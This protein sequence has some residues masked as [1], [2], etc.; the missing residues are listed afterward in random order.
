MGN[1]FSKKISQY[2]DDEIVSAM[3]DLIAATSDKQVVKSAD[4]IAKVFG[5]SKALFEKES[6]DFEKNLI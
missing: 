1:D 5:S 4:I 2:V 3:S 6:S